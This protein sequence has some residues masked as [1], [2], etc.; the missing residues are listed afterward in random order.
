[1]TEEVTGTDRGHEYTEHRES[2]PNQR[3]LSGTGR[4]VSNREVDP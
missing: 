2:D 3:A 1:M 4:G